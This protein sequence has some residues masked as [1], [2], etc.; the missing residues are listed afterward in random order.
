[1][2]KY[3]PGFVN[4]Q[5]SNG[6]YIVRAWINQAKTLLRF[7]YFSS[8]RK[9]GKDRLCYHYWANQVI[10]TQWLSGGFHSY[11]GDSLWAEKLKDNESMPKVFIPLQFVPEATVDYW[12]PNVKMIDYAGILMKAVNAFA[13]KGFLILI[14]EHPGIVGMR[15]YR[16]YRAVSQHDNVIMIPPQ[17]RANSIIPMCKC[18]FVWTGTVGFEAALRGI[19]VIHLGFPYY[20]SGDRFYGVN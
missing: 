18:V 10:A 11:T 15:D 5:K 13:D 12:C 2:E 17:I 16:L 1:D 9:I 19:P 20:I 7:I 14:K 4:G 8:K 6:R 3:L